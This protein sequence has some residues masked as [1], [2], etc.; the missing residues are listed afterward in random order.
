M[1]RLTWAAVKHLGAKRLLCLL[2]G[3]KWTPWEDTYDDWDGVLLLRE[4]QCLRCGEGQ[5]MYADV[6]YCAPIVLRE[7]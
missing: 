5:S 3:H 4:R 6:G 1:G 7:P 2:M